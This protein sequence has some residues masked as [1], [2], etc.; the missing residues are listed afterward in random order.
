MWIDDNG[1]TMAFFAKQIPTHVLQ[2]SLVACKASRL[3]KLMKA[4]GVGRAG[5]ARGTLTVASAAWG[6]GC[7]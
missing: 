4:V 2:K 3:H 6:C 7:G 5:G 1:R